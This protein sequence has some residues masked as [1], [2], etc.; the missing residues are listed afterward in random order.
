MNY[1]YPLLLSFTIIFLAELGDKTQIMILSFSTKNKLKNILLGIALGTFFSHGIAI[2]LGSN[3][4]SISNENF[5]YFLKLF[6]YI[7]FIIF[8]I[9]GLISVKK[10]HCELSSNN[11]TNLNILSKLNNL[12]I[13]YIFIIAFCIFT[14]EL[15]DKTFLSS[16]GLGIQYPKYKISLILGSIFGMICSNILAILFGKILSKKFNSDFLDVISSCLFLIFGISGIISF[17]F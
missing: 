17:I 4:A 7:T 15:G 5:S 10:S 2:F 1:I 6:T 3:L 8:G 16:I 12:K 13:N 9:L 11:Q 14:G